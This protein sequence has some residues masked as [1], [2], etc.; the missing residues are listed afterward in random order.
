MSET[1]Y[2]CFACGA[3]APF[4]GV[5][6]QAFHNMHVLLCGKCRKQAKK[7]AQQDA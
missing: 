4:V 2:R 6:W 7:E 1:L 3:L 5:R